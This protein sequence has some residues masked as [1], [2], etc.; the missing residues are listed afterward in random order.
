MGRLRNRH[1]FTVGKKINCI[2]GKY[3]PVPI[4]SSINLGIKNVS[5]NQKAPLKYFIF[6]FKSVSATVY[7]KSTFIGEACQTLFST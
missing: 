7:Q 6:F 5:G 2:I 4:Y 1:H 3:F